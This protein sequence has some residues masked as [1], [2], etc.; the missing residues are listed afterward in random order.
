MADVS[1]WLATRGEADRQLYE[2]FGKPL[3]GDHLGEYVAIAPDGRTIL[4]SRA[5]DVLQRAVETFGSGN[6]AISQVGHTTLGRWLGL[7]S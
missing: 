3:E 4:G 5:A 2:R 6:F 1:A 7:R